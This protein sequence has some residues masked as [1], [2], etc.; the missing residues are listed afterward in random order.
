[1]GSFLLPK[2]PHFL[3]LFLLFMDPHDTFPV[4]MVNYM[5]VNFVSSLKDAHVN[6]CLSRVSCNSIKKRASKVNLL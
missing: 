1:M 5:K 3:I 2:K 6:C 4:S